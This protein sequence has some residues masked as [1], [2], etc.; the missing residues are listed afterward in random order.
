MKI[1]RYLIVVFL[2][3]LVLILFLSGCMKS[4]GTKEEKVELTISAAASLTDVLEELKISFA[5]HNST[6]SL[7]INYGSSGA[8]QQQ[9]EQGAP[10]DIY[11]SASV[12]QMDALTKQKLIIT[13]SRI[14]LLENA[15]VLIAPKDVTNV[16]SFKALTSNA[17]KRIGIGEPGSVPAGHYAKEVLTAMHLW[18]ELQ[19]KFVLG[20]DVRQV[21]TWVETG[22]VDA[23]IVYMTDARSADV[24]IISEAP[25]GSHSP[26][27]YPAA[28]I[29]ASPQKQAAAEFL[30][31]LTSR[32]ASEIFL[33]HGYKTIAGE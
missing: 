33:R 30:S 7:T 1:R 32:E 25:E 24:S 22:N 3:L 21:L 23:G 18:D 8:L 19:H 31:Y 27:I 5:E 29:A 26:V 6:I 11:I 15:M 4:T 10:I 13:G 14:D 2:F 9:I 17:V 20:K 16:E 28:V 12:K